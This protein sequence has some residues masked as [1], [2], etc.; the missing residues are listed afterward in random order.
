M[1]TKTKKNHEKKTARREKNQIEMFIVPVCVFGCTTPSAKYNFMCSK[2]LA[3]LNAP[4]RYVSIAL[5]TPQA[6]A[7][8]AMTPACLLAC[9][10]APLGHFTLFPRHTFSPS[11]LFLFVHCT[12]LANRHVFL[13]NLFAD[14][15][16]ISCFRI[17]RF[18]III[19][20]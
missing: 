3:F 13:F 17:R 18:I 8:H 5:E 16:L 6:Q 14:I 10:A 9:V 2:I 4:M 7:I 20:T 19:I 15:L 11:H 12:I 1:A